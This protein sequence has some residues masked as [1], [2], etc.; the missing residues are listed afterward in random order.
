MGIRKV[1]GFLFAGIVPLAEEAPSWAEK[2]IS[3]L[4]D[5]R[6][7]CLWICPVRGSKSRCLL[8]GYII[9][10]QRRWWFRRSINP[11]APGP[12]PD[13]RDQN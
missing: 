2:V 10:I 5:A 1:S 3:I 13:G 8:R 11:S 4:V 9:K 12:V 7:V 6:Y